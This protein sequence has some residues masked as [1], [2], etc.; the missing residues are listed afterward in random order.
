MAIDDGGPAFPTTPVS[1]GYS[2]T[3]EGHG[4]GCGTGLS[5]RDYFAI[6]AGKDIVEAMVSDTINEVKAFLGMADDAGYEPKIHWP[7]AETKAR[8]AYADMMLKA[9]KE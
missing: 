6:H 3:T 8:Y 2:P 5:V 7:M 1:H 9:R 4:T